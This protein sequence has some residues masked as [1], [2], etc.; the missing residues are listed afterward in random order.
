MSEEKCFKF[1]IQVR[2]L[3][4]AVMA[5]QT[6]TQS[7]QNYWRNMHELGAFVFWQKEGTHIQ[8]LARINSPPPKPTY[9]KRTIC[10]LVPLRVPSFITG[11]KFI[12]LAKETAIFIAIF[13]CL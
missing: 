10:L 11:Y 12:V 3:L 2:R 6:N 1:W 5:K 8:L 13:V 4:D 7:I 9:V